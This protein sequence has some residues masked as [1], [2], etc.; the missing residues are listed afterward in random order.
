LVSEYALPT[1]IAGAV[2]LA[3]LAPRPPGNR[4]QAWIT[5]GLLLLTAVVTYAVYHHLGN[6]DTRP[7]VRPELQDWGWRLTVL[8]PRLLTAIWEATVGGL[9]RRIG[10][11]DVS[12]SKEMLLG[13]LA[14]IVGAMVL[15]WIRRHYADD[16]S[17]AEQSE[18]GNLR[19]FL[20]L[21][22]AIS[23]GVLPM[24]AMGAEVRTW[25]GSRFWSSMLPLESCSCIYVLSLL[26]RRR[27]L[28]LLPAF[29]GLLA[30]YCIVSDGLLAD[31][32]RQRVAQL[33]DRLESFVPDDGLTVAFVTWDWKYPPRRAPDE[34]EL[35]A[36][37]MWNWPQAKREHFW[38]YASNGPSF[39]DTA[40]VN[41]DFRISALVDLFGRT[42][43]LSRPW[44]RPIKPPEKSAGRQS[45][46]RGH[47]SGALR[48]ASN[49][50]AVTR[51][52]WVSADSTGK[53]HVESLVLPLA[54][55]R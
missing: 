33:G 27:F 37:L 20:T 21:L 32:E 31:R 11:I 8:G 25:S 43:R 9:S 36:R 10:E 16:S 26:L 24:V 5:V 6:A 41:F 13:L 30:G 14:G 1:V 38:A 2:L 51:L 35:N 52:M 46:A 39:R 34:Y 12:G 48:P 45:E 19:I 3:S 4:M 42:P 47:D 22:L 49:A 44:L 18:S 40:G 54:G 50:E 28:P 29:C 15:G 7:T 23:A 55:S 53:L 17:N